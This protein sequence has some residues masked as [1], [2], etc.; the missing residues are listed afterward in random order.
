MFDVTNPVQPDLVGGIEED[1]FDLIIRNND[2]FLIGKS[3][4]TQY[5]LNP[6]AMAE[7]SF[8]SRIEF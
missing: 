5:E 3:A 8:R 4:L 7:F 1:A 6:V 2:L